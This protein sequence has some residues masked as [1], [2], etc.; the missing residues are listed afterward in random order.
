[1]EIANS[2]VPVAA[3]LYQ[4]F[5]FLTVT[6]LAEVTTVKNHSMTLLWDRLCVLQRNFIKVEGSKSLLM[7]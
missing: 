6:Q 1:M 3:V 2:L 5:I 7:N 4:K